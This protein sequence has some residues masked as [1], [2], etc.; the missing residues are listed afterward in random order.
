M[1]TILVLEDEMSLMKLLRH[2]L[3]DYRLIEATSA[4]EALLFFIHLDY[5]VDMLLADLTGPRMSGAEVAV[6]LRSKSP[7]LPVILTSGYP[8][9]NWRER[10][11]ADLRKL[12]ET[13]VAVLQKPFAGPK[14]LDTICDLT[15]WPPAWK[16]RIA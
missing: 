2:T 14:L 3:K 7:D 4:E 12:G 13:S 10:D 11:C 15:G 6:H 8:V 16:V 5:R 1:K 9:C